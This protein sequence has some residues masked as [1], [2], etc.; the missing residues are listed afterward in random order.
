MKTKMN[1]VMSSWSGNDLLFWIG[2]I[3]IQSCSQ[4]IF[5]ASIISSGVFIVDA[6]Y[7]ISLGSAK[8]TLARMQLLVIC[9]DWIKLGILAFLFF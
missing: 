2:F 8:T 1:D 7:C 5:G 4:F 9:L 6:E 3:W